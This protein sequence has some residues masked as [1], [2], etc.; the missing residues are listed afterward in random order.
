MESNRRNSGKRVEIGLNRIEGIQ[1][2]G[3][4]Y[5]NVLPKGRIG[6]LKLW[7]LNYICEESYFRKD[8]LMISNVGLSGIILHGLQERRNRSGTIDEITE[9]V[10]HRMRKLEC[11]QWE[12]KIKCNWMIVDDSIIKRGK[13]IQLGEGRRR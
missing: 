6:G 3:L 12:R 4:K 5:S 8:G 13:E 7:K 11:W 9:I 2:K 1:G 10:W